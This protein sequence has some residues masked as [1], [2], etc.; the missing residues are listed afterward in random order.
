MENRETFLNEDQFTYIPD[1][2]DQKITDDLMK[3]KDW[4][5]NL[6]EKYPHG[7]IYHC[8]NKRCHSIIFKPDELELEKRYY[9]ECQNCYYFTCLLCNKI[10]IKASDV[11]C[12]KKAFYNIR[13]IGIPYFN[14]QVLDHK[15]EEYYRIRKTFLYPFLNLYYLGIGIFDGFFFGTYR[16]SPQDPN[17]NTIRECYKDMCCGVFYCLFYFL[18][19]YTYIFLSLPYFFF[20]YIIVIFFI[21]LLNLIL[22]FSCPKCSN[23][24]YQK[25]IFGIY[26]QLYN[27]KAGIAERH[28]KRQ[29]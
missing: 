21:I 14:T 27:I 11:C 22:N 6:Y 20:Y 23:H 2:P 8:N 12:L 1:Y 28:L 10:I 9:V 4:K 29:Y 18:S 24:Y 26:A 17:E 16:E 25:A 7:K 5:N 3:Y 15:F 19:W 13:Y